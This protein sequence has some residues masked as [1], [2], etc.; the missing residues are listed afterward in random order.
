MTV[1]E[2]YEAFKELV[3]KGKASYRVFTDC[4]YAPLNASDIEIHDDVE[5]I[6][7]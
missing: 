3:E 7:I 4:G 1:Q 5:Q 2:F 6:I